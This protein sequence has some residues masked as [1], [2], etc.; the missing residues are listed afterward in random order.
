MWS[1]QIQMSRNLGCYLKR[2]SFSYDININID[3]SLLFSLFSI[4]QFS[5]GHSYL[6]IHWGGWCGYSPSL[7]L[8][9]NWLNLLFLSVSPSLT[10]SLSWSFSLSLTRSLSISLSLS[11]SPSLVYV[12]IYIHIHLTYMHTN[13]CIHKDSLM[14]FTDNTDGS[15][16]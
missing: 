12:Y 9:V 5:S 1:M 10:S 15:S 4:D 2:S 16:S 3:I 6:Y 7:S 8:L 11:L 14:R 13:T